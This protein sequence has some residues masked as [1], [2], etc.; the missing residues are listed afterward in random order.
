M[1]LRCL[2]SLVRPGLSMRLGMDTRRIKSIP[3][4]EMAVVFG[5]SVS[6]KLDSGQR[7][8]LIPKYMSMLVY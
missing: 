7:G 2:G 8:A 1:R 3:L 6:V 4:N 5:P